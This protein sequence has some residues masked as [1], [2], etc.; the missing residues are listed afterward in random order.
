LALALGPL[1]DGVGERLH[2]P[3]PLDGLRD[4]YRLGVGDLRVDLTGVPL[5]PGTTRTRV[6]LGVG[7]AVVT[8]PADVAVRVDGSATAGEVVAFGRA[9]SGVGVDTRA[10]APGAGGRTLVLDVHVGAG[11][12]QVERAPSRAA[13]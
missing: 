3:A 8:V 6:D 9:A 7:R 1:R 13:G 5:P 10:D 11:R 4:E 2:R 12:V